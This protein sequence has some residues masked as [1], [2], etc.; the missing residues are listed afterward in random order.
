MNKL[1]KEKEEKVDKC[2]RR[3][4]ANSRMECFAWG[5]TGLELESCNITMSI[6]NN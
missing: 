5:F 4:R 3:L 1:G 6:E 2:F